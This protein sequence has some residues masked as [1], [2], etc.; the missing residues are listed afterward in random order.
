MLTNEYI[1]GVEA[2]LRRDRVKAERKRVQI[3]IR[4]R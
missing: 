4:W 1:A 3:Q 2:Q